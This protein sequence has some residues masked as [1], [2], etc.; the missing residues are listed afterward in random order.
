MANPFI[1]V[2]EQAAAW[3][4]AGKGVAIA[5]VVSTWGTSPSPVGSTMAVNEDSAFAGSVS[6]GCVEGAVIHEALE[7]IGGA[8]PRVMKYSVTNDEAWEVGLTCGGTVEVLVAA[9]LGKDIVDTLID[10]VTQRRPVAAAT[11]IK[12]GNQTLIFG[13]RIEGSLSLEGEALA[14]ARATLD[15]GTSSIIPHGDGGI[16]VHAFLPS[17]RLVI[18]GAVHVSQALAAMAELTGFDVIIIDPRQAFAT[19]ERFPNTRLIHQWPSDAFADSPPD[20][21][22]AVVALVH[23]PKIDDPALMAALASNAFYVGALGSVRTHAKRLDR[24]KDLGVSQD[25]L[26]RIHAPVGLDLGGRKPAEIAVSILAEVVQA[27]NNRTPV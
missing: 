13:D 24:L 17:P 27:V 9:T 12:T 3:R 20:A 11:E 16:F 8:G 5:T 7:V 26:D 4:D 10:N 25:D 21:A 18:I 23:D 6:G 2:L 19:D 1:E 22:T 15:T 14:Q